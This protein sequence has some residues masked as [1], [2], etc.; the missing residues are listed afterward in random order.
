MGKCDYCQ[1]DT[2]KNDYCP[3]CG[4]TLYTAEGKIYYGPTKKDVCGCAV[5]ITEKYLIIRKVSNAEATGD[6]VGRAIGLLGVLVAEV[7]SQKVRPHGFYELSI[8]Q[9]GIFPYRNKGIKRKNAIKLITNDGK[10][11]I[12]LFDKPGFVDGIPKVI[13]TMVKNIGDAIPMIEDGSK[14]NY[15]EQYCINPYVT[16]DT[17]DKVK[18][19]YTAPIFKTAEHL[20]PSAPTTNTS[21]QIPPVETIPFVT[22]Q[23]PVCNSA[24]TPDVTPQE[25]IREA[26]NVQEP[27]DEVES[28]IQCS[29]C[30][31]LLPST[32]KFCSQCGSK[33]II[34]KKCMNCGNTLG[35]NDKFCGECGCPAN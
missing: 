33:I 26:T 24:P 25:T 30:G 22:P 23:E 35:E 5:S 20:T 4:T 6:A 15:G 32:N 29:K 7:A 3:N 31:T 17:F 9:K 34:V 27:V 8:F 2:P 10:D 28:R 16:L 1:A 13:K 14:T 19:G 21:S 11:F 18:P 12:L